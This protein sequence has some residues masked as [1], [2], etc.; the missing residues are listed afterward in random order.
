MKMNKVSI[1]DYS[2]TIVQTDDKKFLLINKQEQT[3]VANT[4]D[5]L[6]KIL[7]TLFKKEEDED[8]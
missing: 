5:E 2:V 3:R 4:V 1:N 6:C 8:D 7:R